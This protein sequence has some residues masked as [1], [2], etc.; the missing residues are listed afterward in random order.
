MKILIIAVV[1]IVLGIGAYVVLGGPATEPVLAPAE[2]TAQ[3]ETPIP[4]ESDGG[5][6][7]TPAVTVAYTN[8]GFSPATIAVNVGDTV[9]FVNQ[10]TKSMWVGADVHPSHANYDGTTRQEHCA[11]GAASFDQCTGT[12]SGTT[13]EFTFDKT[14]TFGYH[15]HLGAADT[16]TVIVK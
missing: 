10:S 12:G 16:G 15:N 6:G 7:S 2:E 3:D 4:V 9:R 14:G 11:A 1:V 5:I 8:T 13:W